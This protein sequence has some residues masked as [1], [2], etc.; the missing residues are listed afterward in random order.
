MLTSRA[1][2]VQSRI[3]SGALAVLMADARRDNYLTLAEA[4]SAELMRQHPAC[5]N[6]YEKENYE[7]TLPGSLVD[8]NSL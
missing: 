4:E 2:G 7:R 6:S 3:G 5:R 8:Q 1:D